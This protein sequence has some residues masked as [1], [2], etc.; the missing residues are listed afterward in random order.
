[1]PTPKN[2]LIVTGLDEISFVPEGDNPPALIKLYKAKAETSTP[3][4][5]MADAEQIEDTDFVAKARFDALQ[6]E[7]AKMREERAFEKVA[8]EAQVFNKAMGVVPGVDLAKTLRAIDKADADTGAA[9]RK[10]LNV[11]AARAKQ[12]LHTVGAFEKSGADAMQQFE[13]KVL[14]V[15]KSRGVKRSDAMDI[16]AR[17]NPDLYAIAN[18]QGGN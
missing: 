1:M 3:G 5:I 12:G 16:V 9:I 13:A 10:V 15:C 8:A 2:T 6:E 7:V 4:A 17:E 18:G 14:E 11:Y